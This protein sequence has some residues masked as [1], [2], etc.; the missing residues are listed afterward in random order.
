MN[1]MELYLTRIMRLLVCLPRSIS[2]FLVL[3]LQ[4]QATRKFLN[5]RERFRRARFHSETARDKEIR[6]TRE[7]R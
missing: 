7:W 4:T 6:V 5:K 1:K 2:P 3:Y